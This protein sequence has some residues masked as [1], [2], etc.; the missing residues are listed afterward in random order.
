MI[1]AYETIVD[2][3][4]RL[5]TLIDTNTVNAEL[6]ERDNII[7][8]YV[9]KNGDDKQ[10]QILRITDHRPVLQK[11]IRGKDYARPSV[12]RNSNLSIEFYVPKYG[13]TGKKRRNRFDNTIVIPNTV[14]SVDEFWMESFE[15]KPN[16]LSKADVELIYSHIIEWMFAN[17]IQSNGCL[18]PYIDP[19]ENTDRQANVIEKQSVTSVR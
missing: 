15:Y 4:Q 14:D 18:N 3:K 12:I 11:M 19:L 6:V 17:K 7:S 8:F 10:L 16:L 1:N 5:Q 13:S 2:F 9:Y